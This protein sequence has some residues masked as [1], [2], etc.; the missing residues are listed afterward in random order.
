M[1]INLTFGHGGGLVVRVLAIYSD[2]PS[3]IPTEVYNF[4]VE[5]KQ[6]EAEFGPFKKNHCTNT[7]SKIMIDWGGR[8]TRKSGLFPDSSRRE[9]TNNGSARRLTE[10]INLNFKDEKSC[11]RPRSR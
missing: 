6:K 5:N 1:K 11:R 3:S 9:T 8:K 2:V 10:P 7:I 4:S